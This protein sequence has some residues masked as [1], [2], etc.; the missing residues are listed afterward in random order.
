MICIIS[1]NL[2]TI[3]HKA[4]KEKLPNS[5]AFNYSLYSECRHDGEKYVNLEKHY[6]NRCF[7]KDKLLTLNNREEIINGKSKED[8]I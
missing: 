3:H 6:L 8:I 1:I 2:L 5:D 4:I 7:S